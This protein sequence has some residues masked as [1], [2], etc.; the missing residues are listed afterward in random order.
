MIHTPSVARRVSCPT[1]IG[2]TAELARLDAALT[3]AQS[4]SSVLLFVAG[5]AGIGKSRLIET[6]SGQARER[7]AI[8]FTG[9]CL[10]LAEGAAPYAPFVAALRPLADELSGDELA[11]VLGEAPR[12]LGALLPELCGRPPDRRDGAE[13]GRLYELALGLFRRMA[14]LHPAVL[15]LEDL[16]WI[17]PASADLLAMLG[18]NLRRA[19]V[20][21]IGTYRSDEVPRDHPLHGTILELE[22]SGRAERIEVSGLTHD[23]VAA[24]VTG[25]LGTKP[26][27]RQIASLFDRSEGNP[28]FVEELVAAGPT[29]GE[30][31]ASLRDVLLTRV[32]RLDPATRRV[33]HA[34]ATIGRVGDEELI[35]TVTE[36]PPDEL[37]SALHE[38]VAHRLLVVSGDGYDVRHAL[39]REALHADLLPGQR[40]RLHGAVA[41]ALENSGVP[42]ESARHWY[43]AGN[44][45]RALAGFVAA[46]NAAQA[47]NAWAVALAHYERA[48]RLWPD[49]ADAEARCGLSHAE[50]LALAA[51]VAMAEGETDRAA[52]LT[53][54]SMAQV[55]PHTSPLRA[56]GLHILLGRIR[57]VEGDLAAACAS[58]DDAVALLPTEAS[59]RERAQARAL[60]GHAFMIQSRFT[61]AVACCR[62]A[63]EVSLAVGARDIEGHA[64]NTLGVCLG[65]L[66]DVDGGLAE[67]AGA[68]GIAKSRDDSWEL[69]RTYVNY[70]DALLWAGR[71]ADA[72]EIGME[73]VHV[74]RSLGYGRTTCMCA[75][76][77]TLQALVRLGR[78]PDADRLVDEVNDIEAPPGQRWGVTVAMA[79]LNLRRGRMA[80]ARRQLDSIAVIVARSDSMELV[81]SFHVCKAWLAIAEGDFEESRER[82]RRGLELI[83]GTEYNRIGPQ[84]CS[85]G[86]SAEAGLN[87][88]PE[89]LLKQCREFLSELPEA[90]E[91]VAYGRHAEAEASRVTAPDP[92]AWL[93][94]AATWERLGEPFHVAY[95]R[96]RGAEA[97]LAVRGSRSEA[98]SLLRAAHETAVL[99]GANGMREKIE[100]LSRRG[101][102]ELVP[103]AAE[104]VPGLTAREGEILALLSD[105]RTNRQI[106]EALFISERTVGVHVSRILR[107]LGVANRGAAA[108]LFRASE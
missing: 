84:L 87:G 22:R 98:A 48:L 68:L 60:Q 44:R 41:A 85:I 6:F 24:Q 106:A 38:A 50:L 21:I 80:D 65:M 4:G 72:A 3:Q 88:D 35:A 96:F 67:L 82:V 59:T 81:S 43:A 91:P 94:A 33:L 34:V 90:P 19:G 54:A 13:R 95:C 55:D 78:W 23:E 71:W 63:V 9:G 103:S 16:H 45:P 74:C 86:L 25:I 15:V 8:V 53:L 57:W 11:H 42:A 20:V 104:P 52:E 69:G 27:E 89:E 64:R 92:G 70:S 30:L 1:L 7:D 10:D 77:N 79:E 47:T 75:A 31:T 29:T 18:G 99:L 14:A 101:R 28:F 105:G 17:D 76:G 5:D 93:A 58:Y 73:G 2:R 56:A 108:H 66:G 37:E 36:L 62:E 46:A 12:E 97:V 51:E 107:K 26:A 39:L 40:N 32:E 61:D 83:R 49:V 100:S 102:L